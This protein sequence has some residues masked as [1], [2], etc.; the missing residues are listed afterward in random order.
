MKAKEIIKLGNWFLLIKD[1][2]KIIATITKPN[3]LN[4]NH[5][6]ISYPFGAGAMYKENELDKFIDDINKF[7]SCVY[8]ITI[9][10]ITDDKNYPADLLIIFQDK[11]F[12]NVTI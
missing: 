6:E 9:D 7:F 2:R 10:Q 11:I 8:G 5:W 12:D 4:Y 1:G 3:E